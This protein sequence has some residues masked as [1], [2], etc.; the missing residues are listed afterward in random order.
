M[1]CCGDYGVVVVVCLDNVGSICDV[2]IEEC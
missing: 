2:V 1:W